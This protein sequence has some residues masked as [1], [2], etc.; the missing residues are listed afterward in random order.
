MEKTAAA[1]LSLF[2][3]NVL[4]FWIT[5]YQPFSICKY[6]AVTYINTKNG[7]ENSSVT[8]NQKRSVFDWKTS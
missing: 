3:G 8:K 6:T 5:L 2:T 7:Y 1:F 4:T